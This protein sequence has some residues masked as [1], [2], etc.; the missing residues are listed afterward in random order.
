[1]ISLTRTVPAVLAILTLAGVP[2]SSGTA[3]VASSGDLTKPIEQYSGDEL[4]AFAGRLA[5]G[6]GAERARACRDTPECTTGQRT[7]VRIDA[8]ADAD[9]LG[10]GSVG[11]YGTIAAR[12]INRGPGTETRYGMRGGG[13]QLHLLIV[14]P[15]GGTWRLE[16]LDQQA[17]TWSHRMVASGR[18]NGCGHPYVRGARA[19]FKTCAQGAGGT[20]VSLASA[21][22][23]L[24][25]P[26]WISCASG[27]CTAE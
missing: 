3:R 7:S 10:P 8:V 18:F 23:G 13:R 11:G 9:S 25:S 15:G 21:M 16:E 19:D 6:Q 26:M 22:Q 17:G 5:Y 27:C 20:S 4:A 2:P 24:D 1:M 14:M 12:L